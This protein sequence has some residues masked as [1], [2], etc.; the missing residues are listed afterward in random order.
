MGKSFLKWAGGKHWLVNNESQRF[1]KQ[2]NRYIEPFL[3][4]GSVFF[5]MHPSDSILS[6]VNE[7]LIETYKALRNDYNA[8]YSYLKEHQ[9]NTSKEYYYKIRESNPEALA[10]KAARMIYLN[11]T[12]FNG[13][14]RVNKSGKF[15]V[16]YGTERPLHFDKDK[17]EETSLLLSHA[18][19][20]H[21]DFE[22]TINKALAGDFIFCD[23]PYAVVDEND[24][25]I[26][27]NAEQFKWSDQERLA[28]C[29]IDAKNKGVLVMMTNVDHPRVR[30]LYE[31]DS[32]FKLDTID[33]KCVISGAS[34][35]RKTYKELIVTANY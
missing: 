14:Y 15:N 17:L 31:S 27:Y 28:R 26:G 35:G 7:E 34:T 12:C 32:D 2:F 33:R 13:I 5:F 30:E 4:G 24:R 22:L 19:I 18:E 8:V 29:I 6:D 1:P 11:K 3:G 21:Q 20:L 9:E 10:E 23:P 25:F 16:P